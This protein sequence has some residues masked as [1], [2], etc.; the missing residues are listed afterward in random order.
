MLL[1]WPLLLLLLSPVLA[2]ADRNSERIDVV[3][4]Q[5]DKLTLSPKTNELNDADADDDDDYYSD[6]EQSDTIDDSDYATPNAKYKHREWIRITPSP[7]SPSPS[8]SSSA[9]E[10]ASQHLKRVPRHPQRSFSDN[11][12]DGDAAFDEE[13]YQSDQAVGVLTAQKQ[14]EVGT[15]E[16]VQI[17]RRLYQ[18]RIKNQT[19]LRHLATSHRQ[20]IENE[21]RCKWPQP[22]VIHMNNETSKQYAPRATILHRCDET[23]GCCPDSMVCTVKT[24]VTVELPFWV[25]ATNNVRAQAQMV[26]LTNHTECECVNLAAQRRKRSSQCQCPK[27]FTN[28][29][30]VAWHR[31]VFA[32]SCRCD[33]HLS[34]VTCQRMKNGEEGFA[35]SERRCILRNECSQPICNFGLYSPHSGRCPRPSQQQQQ[36][37]QLG[38]G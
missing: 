14:Q 5:P 33:C 22:R 10:T 17:S 32:A 30:N 29:S 18:E 11:R 27:H 3:T 38:F 37:R 28:F 13:G 20:R 7:P 25:L 35:M 9:T 23:T 34:D 6:N 24:K 21:A 36:Q 26:P 12:V 8:P 2:T 16:M 31:G 1:L 19:Q 4:S 15:Q